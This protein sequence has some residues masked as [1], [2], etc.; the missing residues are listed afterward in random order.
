LVDNLI[1]S[2]EFDFKH[3]DFEVVYVVD[4]FGGYKELKYKNEQI[5]VV[6]YP[7]TFKLLTAI[8]LH[9]IVHKVLP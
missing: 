9:F 1:A 6:H 5:A 4:L 7:L 3:D 2:K 8:T